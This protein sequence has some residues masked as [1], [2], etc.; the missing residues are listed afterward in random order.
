MATHVGN[1][2][3]ASRMDLRRSMKAVNRVFRDRMLRLMSV[4]EPLSTLN[5][6]HNVFTNMV[7]FIC[8]PEVSET[9]PEPYRATMSS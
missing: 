2:F 9:T 4:G 1:Y 3:V 7:K 5:I 6:R 8:W